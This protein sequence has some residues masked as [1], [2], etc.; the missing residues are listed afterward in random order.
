MPRRRAGKAAARA[1]KKATVARASPESAIDLHARFR[2]VLDTLNVPT[3]LTLTMTPQ[4]R[5]KVMM[6]LSDMNTIVT[7][8]NNELEKEACNIPVEFA[9]VGDL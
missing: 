2:A 5:V 6:G 4:P 8:I 9:V 3:Q 1:P 7:A